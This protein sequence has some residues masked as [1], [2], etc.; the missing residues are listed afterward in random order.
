MTS[1]NSFLQSTAVG[2]TAFLLPPWARRAR[3]AGTDPVLVSIFQRG[4]ADGAQ[5]RRPDR[6][7]VLLLEPPERCRS[8]P[9]PSCRSTASSA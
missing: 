2:M 3:A 7:S 4:A 6:R 5:H 9:A 8:S 1:P